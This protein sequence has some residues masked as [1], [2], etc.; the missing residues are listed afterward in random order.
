MEASAP[1][2]GLGPFLYSLAVI[3]SNNPKLRSP[4]SINRTFGFRDRF[5]FCHGL[6]G[7]VEMA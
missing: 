7:D 2:P 4:C 3:G 1:P 6:A 5:G